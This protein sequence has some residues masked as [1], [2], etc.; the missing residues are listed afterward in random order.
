MLKL[1][2]I[3]KC[4]STNIL[5]RGMCPK[6]YYRVR[7]YG[8]P[9]T[10][11][12]IKGDNQ[13]RFWSKIKKGTDEECWPWIAKSKNEGY[14]YINMGGRAGRHELAHRLAWKFTYG[15]I[16]DSENHHGT[17]V[18]HICDNRLCC[19]PNHLRIGSQGENVKDMDRKGRRKTKSIMGINHH[20]S[21]FQ[22]F[23]IRQIRTSSKSNAE[24]GREYGV[25]R[26]TIRCIKL[27]KTWSHLK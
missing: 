25:S 5:G 21:K 14:G 15:E 27:L 26:N 17:V 22:E 20:N 19:N 2:C 6:H 10:V 16:P 12:Q 4:E 24:L 9:H 8:N 11:M 23:D 3:D 18:M 1:C 7:K 13:L